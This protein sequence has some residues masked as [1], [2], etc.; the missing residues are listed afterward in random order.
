MASAPGSLMLDGF[1]LASDVA[2]SGT[3]AAVLLQLRAKKSAAGLSLQTL[4][5]LVFARSLHLLSHPMGLH[6]RPSTLPAVLYSLTDACNAIAG[7]GLLWVVMRFFWGSYEEEKDNFGIQI[8]DLFQCV[9]TTGIRRLRAGVAFSWSCVAVMA[10]VWYCFRPWSGS[11]TTGYFCCFYEAL[12]A[13]A[14][15]PQLWMFNKE[16][17]V[18]PLV[19]SFVVMVAIGRLCVFAFWLSYPYVYPFYPIPANRT[20]QMGV[21]ALNLLILSDFLYYWARAKLRGDKEVVL[22]DFEWMV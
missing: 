17:R 7:I 11:F 10:A 22:G 12:Y 15:L 2:L 19:A 13:V 20:V 9:P 14:L 4:L 21:E 1:I 3:F 6:Y 16:R 18:P 5:A 8:L